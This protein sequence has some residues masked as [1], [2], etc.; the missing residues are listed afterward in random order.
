M[1]LSRSNWQKTA[2]LAGKCFYTVG[3]VEKYHRH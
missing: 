2:L 1:S 3:A